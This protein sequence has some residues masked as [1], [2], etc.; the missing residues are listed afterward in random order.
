M[1]GADCGFFVQRC[2]T[3]EV[4]RE[5]LVQEPTSFRRRVGLISGAGRSPD[6]LPSAVSVFGAV[7]PIEVDKLV[8][9]V[10]DG[11]TCRAVDTGSEALAR[12]GGHGRTVGDRGLCPVGH[13]AA[14]I[15]KDTDTHVR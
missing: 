6:R 9:G 12:G 4:I 7:F 10:P 14:D 5:L 3:A 1:S 8:A 11:G 15:K 2:P 13:K